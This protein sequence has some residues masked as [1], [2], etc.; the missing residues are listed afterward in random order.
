M[1]FRQARQ[2]LDYWYESPPEHELL[3]LIARSH[4][5]E[6][7]SARVPTAEERRA[8]HHAS[9]EARWKAGA[10]NAEQILKSMGGATVAAID[11]NGILQVPVTAGI[12]PFPGVR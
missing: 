10:M 5:W 1:T 4:G 7:K 11:V 8:A 6:F 9:L 12:G 2:V 3:A